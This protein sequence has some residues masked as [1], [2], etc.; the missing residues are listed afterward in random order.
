MLLFKTLVAGLLPLAAA[1]PPITRTGKYLYD[2]NGE[3]FFIKV[4]SQELPHS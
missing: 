1:L 2:Q 3:R 4:S